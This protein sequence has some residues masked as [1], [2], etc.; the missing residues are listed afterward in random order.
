MAKKIL[1]IAP[2]SFPVN[3]AEAIVNIK[4]L[5]VLSEAGYEIDLVSKRR[6]K[7]NY[8][9]D[10]LS[11]YGVKLK[12]LNIVE[13]DNSITLASIFGTLMCLISFGI[14]YPGCHWAYFAKKI[15]KK[16]CK[17]NKY[18]YILTKDT[19]SFIIE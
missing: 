1:L 14:F 18:E 2:S 3:G 7:G 8:P 4:L 6:K 13:V 12:S 19:P 10:N 5:K 9:S 15:V 16:L 11:S 17:E